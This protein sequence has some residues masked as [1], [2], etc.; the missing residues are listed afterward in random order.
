M[1]NLEIETMHDSNYIRLTWLCLFVSSAVVAPVTTLADDVPKLEKLDFSLALQPGTYYSLSA[2]SSS[3]KLFVGMPVGSKAPQ[4]VNID[5]GPTVD[6]DSPPPASIAIS[7]DDS[8]VA[9][10]YYKGAAVKVFDAES[11]ALKWESELEVERNQRIYKLEFS[12]DGSKLLGASNTAHV[13][14]VAAGSR[15]GPAKSFDCY[16]GY[17]TFLNDDGTLLLGRGERVENIQGRDNTIAHPI[18]FDSLTGD[19]VIELAAPTDTLTHC[20]Q[21][22]R[23]WNKVPGRPLLTAELVGRSDSATSTAIGVWN[24]ETGK[25]MKVIHQSTLWPTARSSFKFTGNNRYIVFPD[26]AFGLQIVSTMDAKKQISLP[27]EETGTHLIGMSGDARRIA[28]ANPVTNKVSFYAAPDFDQPKQIDQIRQAIA[29]LDRDAAERKEVRGTLAVTRTTDNAPNT[30][31]TPKPHPPTLRDGWLLNSLGSDPFTATGRIVGDE[32]LMCYSADVPV[33]AE[34]DGAPVWHHPN[35]KLFSHFAMN[36]IEVFRGSGD[37]VAPE[38]AKQILRDEQYVFVMPGGS[39]QVNWANQ[40]RPDAIVVC[41]KPVAG[42]N[43]DDTT[44]LP[45]YVSSGVSASQVEAFAKLPGV[46]ERMAFKPHETLKLVQLGAKPPKF[47]SHMMVNQCVPETV[48][49]EVTKYKIETVFRDVTE[50]VDGKLETKRQ[51]YQ[52]TKPYQ[53]TVTY[54]VM[55]SVPVGVHR[56]MQPPSV[57]ATRFRVNRVPTTLSCYR[58]TGERIHPLVFLAYASRLGSFLELQPNEKLQPEMITKNIRRSAVVAQ[59]ILH[60]APKPIL[61]EAAM[62]EKL[63]EFDAQLEAGEVDKARATLFALPIVQPLWAGHF[64]ELAYHQHYAGKAGEA[65]ETI[66]A[67]AV[68]EWERPLEGFS[69]DFTKKHSDASAEWLLSTRSKVRSQL[70]L[71]PIKQTPAF[72]TPAPA[73][74]TSSPRRPTD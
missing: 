16:W 7:H 37:Q 19:K 28:V 64:Y 72:A 47:S 69:D 36:R 52:V 32:L 71:G 12:V 9:C 39:G 56:F 22:P 73:S 29:S 17:I 18:I 67:G 42:Q 1:T 51:V 57:L 34:V 46:G 41:M 43:P 59:F 70:A 26:P 48:T 5:S 38:K 74:P 61:N 15:I 23:N 63:A 20:A 4:I 53:E 54:T 33:L 40:L 3:G 68:L 11:G 30:P 27:F 24:T 44:Y 35:Q 14:D 8:L 55:K 21:E 25:F 2:F 62:R 60:N 6:L 50:T 10:S 45:A 49:A 66:L 13:W 65:K 58:A 31:Q